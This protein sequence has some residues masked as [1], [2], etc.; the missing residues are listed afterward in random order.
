MRH[1]KIK[2]RGVPLKVIILFLL[3]L[4]VFLYSAQ[5]AIM[6]DSNN[7][8]VYQAD[9]KHVYKTLKSYNYTDDDIFVLYY[10]GSQLDL[11]GDGQWDD[12]D[13]ACTKQNLI[14]VFDSLRNIVQDNDVVFFYATNHGNREDVNKNDGVDTVLIWLYNYEKLYNYE[15]FAYL[16]SLDLT[17]PIS[18]IRIVLLQPCFSGGFIKNLMNLPYVSV[19]T[20][21]RVDESASYPTGSGTLG[22]GDEFTHWWTS[23]LYGVEWNSDTAVD[24][25]YDDNGVVT[26]YEAFR[27]ARENDRYAQENSNPKET[28]SWNS[29]PCYNFYTLTI[30]GS[31][32]PLVY[33]LIPNPCDPNPCWWGDPYLGCSHAGFHWL[34]R[35]NLTGTDSLYLWVRN[36]GN[37]GSTSSLVHFYYSNPTIC[38]NTFD[39]LWNQFETVE[40]PPLGP[41][42]SILIGPVSFSHPD[43]NVFGQPFFSVAAYLEQ[44]EQP[45]ESGWLLEDPH[46]AALNYFEMESAP[47]TPETLRF[48]IKNPLSDAAKII[49]HMD[50]SDFP[51]T[52]SAFLEPL[53]EETLDV[54]EGALIPATLSL[55]GT[56]PYFQQGTVRIIEELL[57]ATASP[58]T[59]CVGDTCGGFI[60]NTGGL[61][62]SLFTGPTSSQEKR[63]EPQNSVFLSV[64]PNPLRSHA[65]ITFGIHKDTKVELS[66]YDV[67]GRKIQTLLKGKKKAGIYKLTWDRLHGPLRSLPNGSYILELKVGRLRRY[68]RIT[69]LQ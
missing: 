4:P 62:V 36:I 8:T 50:L 63:E 64:F 47:F 24:A 29:E 52:W 27:F 22:W 48:F 25:D 17:E 49:L 21:C 35:T 46:V 67:S 59:C 58:C 14:N 38:I 43:E 1:A 19:T 33:V 34:S 45:E 37:E 65:T 61:T 32:A 18:V 31:A 11:D 28:P 53:P 15:L 68:K 26:L 10:N 51:E 54:S 16:D 69:L 42:D 56:D 44:T 3:F 55:E 6:V 60:R 57:T 40:V 39:T 20:A 5:Y 7:G 23:A 41:G 9:L 66:L 2:D 30:D 13:Y 12:V